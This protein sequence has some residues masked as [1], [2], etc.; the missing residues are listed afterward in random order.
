M[1]KA[2]T[3]KLNWCIFWLKMIKVSSD[4]KKNS[5]VNLSKIKKIKTKIKSYRK[6]AREF[7]NRFLDKE[8]SKISSNHTF[9]LEISSNE[10]DE[11]KTAVKTFFRTK[12]IKHWLLKQKQ[13]MFMSYIPNI[14][15]I[16]LESI[17]KF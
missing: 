5:I 3:I 1:K 4:I 14:S 8:V 15:L 17:S 10:S 12:N 2:I 7:L 11:E 13:G 9:L 6:E 16:V